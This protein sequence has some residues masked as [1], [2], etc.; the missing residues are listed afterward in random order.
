[1]FRELPRAGMPLCW[2]D[3]ARTCYSFFFSA[4][5]FESVFARWL[6]AH[7]AYVVSSGRAALWLILRI[8]KESSTR[9]EVVI[10]A[11]TCPTVP[12]AV[13]RTGLTV[14]LCDVNPETGNIDIDCLSRV[15][16]GQSLCVIVVH[17]SGIPCDMESIMKITRQYEVSVVEDCAQAAG[18]RLYGKRVGTFGDFAFFSLGRGKGFTTYNGGIIVCQSER[19]TGLIQEEIEQTVCFRPLS[20][21]ATITKL[22]GMTFFFHPRLY[23][24]VRSLPLG[25]ENEFYSMDFPLEKMGGFRKRA[26]QRVL[27]KLDDTIEER[28]VKGEYLQARLKAIDGLRIFQAS[29]LSEPAYPWLAFLF[30][31]PLARDKAYKRLRAAGLGPSWLFTRSLNQYDYLAHIMPRG[32]HHG[33]EYVAARLLTLPTHG[34]VKQPDLDMMVKIIAESLR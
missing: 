20:E 30:K 11:Y 1:M 28:R 10:P 15:V 33:A 6:P 14:R 19:Y 24:L 26:A 18:A 9:N 8:L 32:L 23:W 27:E 5:E 7:K 34:H 29:Q 3:I 2:K 13:A 16:T 22:L 4:E 25:W 21:L 12:L 17:M 31:E